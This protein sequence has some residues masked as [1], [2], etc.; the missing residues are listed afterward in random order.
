MGAFVHLPNATAGSTHV[1][2]A[3]CRRVWRLRTGP[4]E[5]SLRQARCLR[6][7]GGRRRGE[8]LTTIVHLL[9]GELALQLR[10]G[11]VERLVEGPRSRVQSSREVLRVHPV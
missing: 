9:T 3:K 8:R 7:V 6:T 5:D 11:V 1:N 4:A 2:G 10:A